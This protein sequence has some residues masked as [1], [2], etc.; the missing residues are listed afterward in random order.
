M[1]RLWILVW[2]VLA[3][4]LVGSPAYANRVV[5]P[6][7]DPAG[8]LGPPAGDAGC[9]GLVSH[10]L[11]TV[12]DAPALIISG[13]IIEANA[14]MPRHCLVE[15]RIAPTISYRMWLPMSTWNGKFIQGGCGG[16][17]GYILDQACEIVVARGYACIAAD[18]GHTGTM[19]DNLWAIDN[20]AGQIDFGFRATH[21][22]NVIGKTVTGIFYGRPPTRSYYV[23]A[24][25]GGRQG[26]V[27]AERFPLDFD[28]V[29]VGEPAMGTPGVAQPEVGP[30]LFRAVASILKDGKPILTLPEI[31][32]IHDHAVALCD[33][34][35]NLKDGI[36]SDPR[37]CAFKPAMMACK[38]PKTDDCLTPEQV[39]GVAG[40]Y[41]QGA[42]PGSEKA[43]IGAYVLKDGSAGRY[44]TRVGNPYHY[45]YAW[46][47]DDATNPDLRAFKA[48]GG[49]LILYQGWADEAVFP[50]NPVAFYDTVQRLFGGRTATQDFF[51]LYMI[52]G[53]SHI[54]QV[55]GGAETVDYLSYLEDWVERG[56]A[57]DVLL[58][59]HMKVLANF[60][61]PVTYQRYLTPENVAFSRPIWPY[62][63]MARYA[64][65]GD[66]AMA[67]SWT[68]VVPLDA[69][70]PQ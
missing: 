30:A 50:G 4:A 54:P 8:S 13:K 43:W 6:T 23:G 53:Q 5:A 70:T 51:R 65:K 46:I 34:D 20:V 45:P 59:Q 17:C 55:T 58:G 2:A 60:A 47:F 52:P 61:G 38:G 9:A 31:T 42:L 22:T 25:T 68:P 11:S 41:A 49:K 10:D 63:T 37:A 29:I 32:A 62:P 40:V 67:D 12:K 64:G 33:M 44:G 27:E 39:T 19:Y 57:P 24:S 28:G 7:P 21:V 35:D 16:R 36:I 69:R 56:H 14:D 66:P 18:L 15:G 48:H 26:L 1:Q 3:L